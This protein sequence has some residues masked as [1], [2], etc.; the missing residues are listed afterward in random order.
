MCVEREILNIYLHAYIPY[1][2]T[3]TEYIHTYS[4]YAQNISGRK[5]VAASRE[6]NWKFGNCGTGTGGRGR[7]TFHCTISCVI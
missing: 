5:I 6:M 3:C 2:Y 1:T 4:V 7:L